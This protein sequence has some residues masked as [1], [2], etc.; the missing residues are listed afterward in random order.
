VVLVLHPFGNQN[1]RFLINGLQQHQML[2]T[3][4]TSIAWRKS[5]IEKL[6]PNKI[7]REL[8]RREYIGIDPHCIHTYPFTDICRLL[9]IK[10][11][12]RLNYTDLRKYFPSE[13]TCNYLDK[14]TALYIEKKYA[15]ISTI[16]GYDDRCLSSFK[17]GKS[18]NIKLV[19]ESAFGYAK[20]ANDIMREEE[21]IEPDWSDYLSGCFQGI[22]RSRL[23]RIDEELELADHIIVAS[24]YAKKTLPTK[25]SA[26]NLTIINYGAPAVI[27]E[28]ALQN[29]KYNSK[30]LKVLYI[31]S[32]RQQ[33][34]ISYLFNAID[35]LGENIE[36]YLVGTPLT[37]NLSK[38]LTTHLSR[39]NWIPSMAH[40]Q[41]LEYIYNFDVLILP[42]L[43]EAFGLVL[44]EAMS[45][46]LPVIATE[47]TGAPDII[48]HGKE[49][50]I[51][52]IRDS[53]SIANHLCYL[54]ENRGELERMSRNAWLRASELT[55]DDY[56]NTILSTLKNPG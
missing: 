2:E 10:I 8:K 17:A 15:S 19:Y 21:E 38:T 4:H 36:L 20:F 14:K 51:V 9:S 41:L 34:G 44:L 46:G 11:D 56:Q 42:S 40:S 39:H 31:G 12:N 45:R 3:F 52:P 48:T 35:K 33:K 7:L 24:T 26:K 25:L 22:S 43:A 28:E 37:T 32:L 53:D 55:W 16:Y 6:I 23:E 54:D 30:K 47:N 5:A 29:R 18:K 27:S 50:F 49:G 13:L 1:V